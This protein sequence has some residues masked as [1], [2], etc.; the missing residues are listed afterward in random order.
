MND[1]LYTEERIEELHS[2]SIPDEANEEIKELL[3]N[4]GI[5]QEVRKL[6][7]EQEI[8][9]VRLCEVL[10]EKNKVKEES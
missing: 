4:N 10:E 2:E 3:E 1:H 5:L 6:K 8:Y 7:R 9:L